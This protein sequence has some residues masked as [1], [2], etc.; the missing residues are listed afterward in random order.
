M[1]ITNTITMHLDRRGVPETI[2]AMQSDAYSRNVAFLLYNNDTPW[3]P[4]SD[5]V[6][7]VRYVK[8]DGTGGEYDTLPDG[9][10]AW[11]ITDNVLT[12][13][14]APQVL[15]VPGPVRL[16]AALISGAVEL[17]TFTI[18]IHVI[19]NPGLQV[20]S[21]DYYNAHGG[22]PIPTQA[23]VGE[24]FRVAAVDGSG[25]VTATE[26][27][28]LRLGEPVAYQYGGVELPALPE[29]DREA[30]PYAVISLNFRD[31][32]MEAWNW[33][34]LY[35]SNVPFAAEADIN[36]L[37]S[38]TVEGTAEVYKWTSATGVWTYDGTVDVNLERA[39]GLNAGVCGWI[40][41]NTDILDADGALYRAA[42]DPVPVY[43]AGKSWEMPVVEISTMICVDGETGPAFTAEENAALEAAA[44]DGLP[45]IAKARLGTLGDLETPQIEMSTV[46]S[47]LVGSGLTVYGAYIGT[48]T[49]VLI[50]YD[51]GTWG[52]MWESTSA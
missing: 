1:I 12:V 3:E 39:M 47:R 44:A 32:A 27:V 33:A 5:A 46:F 31:S 23:R 35:L 30:C 14:L 25:R 49:V 13:M 10:V 7:R 37:V 24:Y 22:V 9:S 18:Q 51:D 19:A 16:T 38:A 41:T 21:Q 48:M 15:T 29:W 42:S 6:A 28:V 36:Y 50:R 34:Y 17:H 20:Q 8:T 40:W 2:S 26:P 52:A 45:F 11:S 4:P 43:E